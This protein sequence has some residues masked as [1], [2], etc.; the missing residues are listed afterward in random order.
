[1]KYSYILI[2]SVILLCVSCSSLLDTDNNGSGNEM[3]VIFEISVPE[4]TPQEDDVYLA[5]NI[6]GWDPEDEQYRATSTAPNHYRLTIPLETSGTILEYKFTRGGWNTVEKYADGSEMPNRTYT[7]QNTGETISIVIE[8]W[9]DLSGG[10]TTITGNVIRIEDFEIP[11]L[12]RTRDL[13]IYLPPD[14]ETEPDKQYP[15]LYMHDGQNLF[16]DYTSFA[17]EWGVDETLESFFYDDESDGVIVVGIEN[18]SHRIEEYT[19]WEFQY[20]GQTVGGE[21]DEYVA[22]IIETLKPYIDENFRTDSERETTGIAGSSLGGLISFYAGMKHQD[23]FGLIGAFSSSF[24]V[25]DNEILNFLETIEKDDDMRIYLDAGQLEGTMEG[26]GNSSTV[27]DM[28]GVYDTLLD[29][30]FNE[31]ELNMIIDPEGEHNEAAWRRRFPPAFL[32]L[33]D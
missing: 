22:F 12:G 32:W 10:G 1:M 15:V 17:G 9:A 7:F 30:G 33:F 16:D 4:F 24:W 3:S 6:N 27:N 13:L 19:P 31:I 18:S 23:T 21:G 2:C 29:M 28:I 14:Y 25:A 26:N 11:Q 5:G 20:S 8:N